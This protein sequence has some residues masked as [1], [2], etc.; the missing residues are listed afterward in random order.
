MAEIFYEDG[1]SESVPEDAAMTDRGI[2]WTVDGG[3]SVWT[4]PWSAVKK[5]QHP[6]PYAAVE[7]AGE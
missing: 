6:A 4:V 7:S 1:D 3:S 2:Q 5:F